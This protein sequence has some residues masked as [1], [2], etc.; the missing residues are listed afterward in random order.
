MQGAIAPWVSI[1][2]IAFSIDYMLYSYLL[3]A[4]DIS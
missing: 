2:R 1:A 3:D 4:I